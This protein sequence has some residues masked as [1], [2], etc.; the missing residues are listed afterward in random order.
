MRGA[1]QLTRGRGSATRQEFHCPQWLQPT[2]WLACNGLW[3][4]YRCTVPQPR[5]SSSSG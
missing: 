5:I 2:S 4:E 3:L 1:E